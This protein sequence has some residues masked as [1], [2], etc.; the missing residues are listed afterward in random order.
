MG[1]GVA[2]TLAALVL[3]ELGARGFERLV[4]AD[5]SARRRPRIIELPEPVPGAYRIFL[6]GGSTVAGAPVNEFSF[7]AQLEFW[8]RRLAPDRPLQIVNFAVS[9]RPSGF[10]LAELERTL[11]AAP[12]LA[13][14]LTAHNEFLNWEPDTRFEAWRRRARH[15]LEKTATGRVFRR[16]GKTL[17]RA[18]KDRLRLPSQIEPED[19]EGAKF[20][21][22]VAGY[23]RNTREIVSRL[24]E[25]R[26]P[27][28]LATGP[29]NLSDWPPV[30]RFTH[31][32]AYERAVLEA[33]AR[34]ERG[35]L[36]GARGA[37]TRLRAAHPSDP[38]L[39]FLAGRSDASRGRVRSASEHFDA[40]R[41][42]D[43]L[44][45][46]VLGAFND[47]VRRLATADGVHLAD[48]DLAFRRVAAD[49]LVGWELVADNCHPTPQGNAVIAREL[50]GVMARERFFL[51]GL[52]GLPAL[53]RQATR[54]REV[55]LDEQPGLWLEYLLRNASYVM[56]WPF[57][58][59]A[60]ASAYLDEAHALAPDDWRVWANRG[61]VSVLEGRVEEGRRQLER[62]AELH[63][64]PLREGDRG[65]TP[66]LREARAIVTG[67][68]ERFA[69]RPTD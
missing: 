64:G 15:Q 1:L 67:E 62:A 61:T 12:D 34:I 56:K 47:H 53:E 48:L 35:E 49:G 26:V 31:D 42:G 8:L 14:V 32:D 10:V 23:R 50:L 13:I 58:H 22:R 63:G 33:G 6:Y 43:P 46:R 3:L 17:R 28:I 29:A 4:P 37:L 38:M 65:P 7:A 30:H 18:R 45:W 20:R 2:A 52:T 19:R 27:L 68:I 40:A 39:R 51:A 60:A 24:R 41:D 44:P 66:Y 5:P 69:P 57:L 54:F 25:A 36:D 9:G 21:E 16:L 55:V 59:F 11:P